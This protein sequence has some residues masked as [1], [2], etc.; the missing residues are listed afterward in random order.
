MKVVSG[1][2]PHSGGQHLEMATDNWTEQKATFAV[3]LSSMAGR[4]N[5]Y[6]DF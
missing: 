5:L 6:L 3:D 1:S 2:S 4:T